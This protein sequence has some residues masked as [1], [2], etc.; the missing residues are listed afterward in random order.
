M[1]V[2]QDEFQLVNPT[3]QIA[4]TSFCVD[5][6]NSSISKIWN[7]LSGSMNSTT[8]TIEWTPFDNITQY[9]NIWFFGE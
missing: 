2:A 7:I 4:L 9:K 8:Q 6:C 5:Q 1:C 3:T